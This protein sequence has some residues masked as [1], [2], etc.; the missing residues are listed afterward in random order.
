MNWWSSDPVAG[1]E[2]WPSAL[3]GIVVLGL[4]VWGLLVLVGVM[5]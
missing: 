4:V 3:A 2:S 5:L 1:D